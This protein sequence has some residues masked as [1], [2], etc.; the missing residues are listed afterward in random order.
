M[1]IIIAVL[2]TVAIL[3]QATMEG[4]TNVVTFN[5]GATFEYGGMPMEVQ[6]NP[7]ENNI[8]MDVGTGISICVDAVPEPVINAFA[9]NDIIEYVNL[10]ELDNHSR[11]MIPLIRWF[12]TEENVRDEEVFEHIL[13]DAL[14]VLKMN[15][16]DFLESI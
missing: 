15:I 14:N 6:V 3:A 2:I 13:S 12:S 8:N 1:I 16:M 4:L 11:V 5:D 7:N 9:S 10:D